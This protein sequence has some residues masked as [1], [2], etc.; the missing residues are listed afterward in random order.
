[1]EIKRCYKKFVFILS[2]VA[3][4]ILSPAKKFL[5]LLIPF[6]I[7]AIS[8]YLSDSQKIVP[9]IKLSTTVQQLTQPAI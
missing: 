1:M 7:I 8:I 9:G 6:I 5:A 2:M 4:Y 3:F